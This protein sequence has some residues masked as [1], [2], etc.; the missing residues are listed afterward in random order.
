MNQF[1][2]LMESV[3]YPAQTNNVDNT[4]LRINDQFLWNGSIFKV[5]NYINLQ[6]GNFIHPFPYDIIW[7]SYSPP[8]I[9]FFLWQ[10]TKDCIPTGSFLASRLIIDMNNSSCG[11][12]G[13]MENA[14]HILLHCAVAWRLWCNLL[15]KAGCVWIMPESLSSFLV[16]WP[17]VFSSARNR[18]LWS[19]I[20]HLL[21]WEVWKARN[22]RIF[23]SHIVDGVTSLLVYCKRSFHLQVS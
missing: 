4:D 13:L 20:G 1:L 8:K 3:P 6:F 2:Q 5:S 21:L 7:K 14:N 18:K 22:E 17:Y 11:L 12:C 16:Q 23:N 15:K 10:A 9:K 19:L